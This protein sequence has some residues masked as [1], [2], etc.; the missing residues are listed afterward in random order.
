MEESSF[1]LQIIYKEGIRFR[2]GYCQINEHNWSN[3]LLTKLLKLKE[4]KS[5]AK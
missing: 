1:Y 3:S 2:M 4:N 5:A